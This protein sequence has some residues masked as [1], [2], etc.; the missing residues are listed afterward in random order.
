MSEDGRTCTL[1]DPRIA[2]ALQ[3]TTDVYDAMGGVSDVN[4][5]KKSFQ[6][7][8]QD[9]F[10]QKRLEQ[11]GPY[12]GLERRAPLGFD[13]RQVTLEVALPHDMVPQGQEHRVFGAGLLAAGAGHEGQDREGAAAQH[14]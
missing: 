13:G 3:F 1:D 7:A 6:A 14:G 2:E 10:F 12:R 9:P 8:A 4:A 5:F 11:R